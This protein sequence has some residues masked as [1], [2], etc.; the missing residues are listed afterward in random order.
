MTTYPQGTSMSNTIKPG[1]RGF[2]HVRVKEDAAIMG[3]ISDRH[4]Y[5]STEKILR[6]CRKIWTRLAAKIRRRLDKKA[7]QENQP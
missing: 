7:I 6:R 2:R 3:T 5:G 1:K 4:S